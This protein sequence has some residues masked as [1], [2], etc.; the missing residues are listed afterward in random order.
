MAKQPE[1]PPDSVEA[2]N[3]LDIAIL[4]NMPKT[5]TDKERDI[6]YA[7]GSGL[8]EADAARIARCK[9]VDVTECLATYAADIKS[10]RLNCDAV[11]KAATS[12]NVMTLQIGLGKL[13]RDFAADSERTPAQANTLTQCAERVFRITHLLST[14]AQATDLHSEKARIGS[15]TGLTALKANAAAAE[16]RR[17]KAA[18]P[19]TRAS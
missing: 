2:L 15:E 17:V 6:V 9:P 1:S 7:L 5:A 10:I 11:L 12:Q 13:L 16:L 3:A 4:P 8:S 19:P 18:M 14:M